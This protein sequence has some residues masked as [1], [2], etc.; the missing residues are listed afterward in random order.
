MDGVDFKGNTL[1]FS[2]ESTI[3]TKCQYDI[4]T[5]AKYLEKVRLSAEYRALGRIYWDD[6][7]EH[8]QD[9]KGQLN[10]SV[11]LI[12]D[13]YSLTMWV[14]NIALDGEQNTFYFES[15]GKSFVQKAMP[16]SYGVT[17]KKEL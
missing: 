9:Y 4:P 17:L 3:S 6:E 14:N 2:P 15:M 8:M 13:K 16:V 10:A 1:P 12:K 5:N 11:G 7:N